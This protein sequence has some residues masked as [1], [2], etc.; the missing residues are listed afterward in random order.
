MKTL[1][2]IPAFLPVKP[3]QPIFLNV[4]SAK[5]LKW[6][7]KKYKKLK[8]KIIYNNVMNQR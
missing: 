4:N 1:M 2:K 3:N 8:I 6:P 5:F 7:Q